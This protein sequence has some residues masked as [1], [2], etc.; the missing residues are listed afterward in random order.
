MVIKEIERV[1]A[2]FLRLSKEVDVLGACRDGMFL[3]RCGII[4]AH[5]SVICNCKTIKTLLSIQSH[6]YLLSRPNCSR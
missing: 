1:Y 2:C 5:S 3:K 4:T 6:K